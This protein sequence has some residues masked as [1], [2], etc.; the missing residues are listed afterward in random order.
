MGNVAHPFLLSFHPHL[1]FIEKCS[2]IGISIDA[3]ETEQK[4]QVLISI[5]WILYRGRADVIVTARSLTTDS[6]GGGKHYARSDPSYI[7]RKDRL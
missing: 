5:P 4:Q 3:V 1:T 6:T 7:S 2:I